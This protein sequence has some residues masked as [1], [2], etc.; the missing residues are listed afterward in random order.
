MSQGSAP[1]SPESEHDALT[2]RADKLVSVSLDLDNVRDHSRVQ[3]GNR[4]QKSADGQVSGSST[5]SA[6]A[7]EREGRTDRADTL[8]N[9]SLPTAVWA[10]MRWVNF[11]EGDRDAS[12]GASAVGRTR[13]QP[14]LGGGLRVSV[15]SSELG[16][17]KLSRQGRTLG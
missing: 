15:S 12:R 5:T 10:P 6:D 14:R 13:S 4:R 11:L 9:V 3:P 1:A 17:S 16:G 2:H 8:G 7:G